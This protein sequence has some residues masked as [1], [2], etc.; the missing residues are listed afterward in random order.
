MTSFF[1]LK[2]CFLSCYIA[3]CITLFLHTLCSEIKLIIGIAMFSAVEVLPGR[4]MKLVRCN[5]NK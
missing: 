1:L 5:E 4:E 2:L 3:H